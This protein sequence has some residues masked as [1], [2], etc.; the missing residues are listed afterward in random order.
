MSSP[1][2]QTLMYSSQ[3]IGR[4]NLHRG[5][6]V[7]EANSIDSKCQP[8]DRTCIYSTHMAHVVSKHTWHNRLGHIS[9]H[10]MEKL[11]DLLNYKNTKDV[12]CS[13]CPLAK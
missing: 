7:I 3:M 5:L 11:K 10:K 4:G 13:I 1:G 9:F 12:S 8:I 6:Y 2:C